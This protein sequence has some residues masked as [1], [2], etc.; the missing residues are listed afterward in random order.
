MGDESLYKEDGGVLDDF[1]ELGEVGC[2][3][4][5]VDDPVVAAHADVEAPSRTD[6]VVGVQ[7]RFCGDSTNRKDGGLGGVDDGVKGFDSEG[8]EA[9]NREGSAGIVV[10]LPETQ[11]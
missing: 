10:R 9:R 6:L 2:A 11:Y 4:G 7:D 8:A 3:D 1:L 5:S